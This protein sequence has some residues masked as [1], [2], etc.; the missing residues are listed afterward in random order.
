MIDFLLGCIVGAAVVGSSV[1]RTLACDKAELNG[2][3]WSSVINSAAYYCSV[4]WISQSNNVA[5]AG[6]ALGST[7]IIIYMTI[8]NK[9]ARSGRS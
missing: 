1:W 3:I 9:G 6:T 4:H 2:A 5:Y 8:R 7:A